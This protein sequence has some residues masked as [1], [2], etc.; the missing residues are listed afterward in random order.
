VPEV[1]KR[2]LA[3]KRLS[4]AVIVFQVNCTLTITLV[5]ILFASPEAELFVNA[6]M[7]VKVRLVV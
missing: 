7:A 6:Y 3:A 5:Y 1:S 4:L 2:G